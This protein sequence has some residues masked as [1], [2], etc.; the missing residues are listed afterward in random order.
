[1]INDFYSKIG[2]QT[3]P[4][5]SYIILEDNGLNETFSKEIEINKDLID[6]NNTIYI[7]PI[8]NKTNL[9]LD[10]YKT[11]NIFQYKKISKKSKSKLLYILIPIISAIIIIIVILLILRHRKKTSKGITVDKVLNEELT[12]IDK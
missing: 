4:Y 6:G 11:K 9:F 10:Y 12:E 3:K 5:E 7:V 8:F 1:M 2:S